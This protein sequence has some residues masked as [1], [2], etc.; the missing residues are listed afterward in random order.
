MEP[1]ATQCIHQCWEETVAL[2]Q[3]SVWQETLGIQATQP[4]LIRF[5]LAQI[6]DLGEDAR[7]AALLLL[8]G[9]FR[10]FRQAY[11][12]EILPLPDEVFVNIPQF[13]GNFLNFLE[14]EDPYFQE[15][16]SYENCGQP[17][18]MCQVAVSLFETED[19]DSP[20]ELA[21]KEVVILYFLCWT[22]IKMLNRATEPDFEER[23][24]EA[25]EIE[26]C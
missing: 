13:D 10:T 16:L 1:I 19:D 14:E 17:M 18:L 4:A 15:V 26:E 3:K 24:R 6:R 7:Q 5:L 9:C 22:V 12:R 20:L 8:L 25:D 2:D 21:T 23:L 11:G